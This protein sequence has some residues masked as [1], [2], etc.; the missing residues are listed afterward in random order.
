[1]CGNEDEVFLY[2]FECCL[3]RSEPGRRDVE[4]GPLRSLKILDFPGIDREFL[5][6]DDGIQAYPEF[7]VLDPFQDQDDPCPLSG[8]HGII[9]GLAD[10]LR[11]LL[12]EVEFDG[13][14]AGD[15]IRPGAVREADFRMAPRF[16]A[17]VPLVLLFRALVLSL[18][19]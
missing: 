19:W 18:Y 14:G 17:P 11:P 4:G 12:P 1:M 3:A 13:V 9:Q 15:A 10:G 7:P 2:H 8:L 6:F 16:R 5:E